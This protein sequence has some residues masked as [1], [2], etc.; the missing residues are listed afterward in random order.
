MA[1][2]DKCRDIEPIEPVMAMRDRT[3][4]YWR[5]HAARDGL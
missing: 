4:A 5:P 1:G 3:L 2:D